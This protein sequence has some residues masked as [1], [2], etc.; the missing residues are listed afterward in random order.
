MNYEKIIL[1]LMSRIQY[2]EE[3]IEKLEYRVS[4][5]DVIGDERSTET[6]VNENTKYTRTDARNRIISRIS[7]EY[8]DYSVERAS[9]ADGSGIRVI[10]LETGD[11]Y[12]IKYYHSKTVLNK[13]EGFEY[14]DHFIRVRELLDTYPKFCIFSLVDSSDRWY[15]FIYEIEELLQYHH[16]RSQAKNDDVMHLYFS[17][18]SDEA[19]I[20]TGR[21]VGRENVSKHLD[22]WSILGW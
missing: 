9:R 11:Q 12:I 3:A 21:D 1:E 5:I 20:T 19:F 6:E 15:Y 8:P 7:E 16:D 13:T 14:G 2:L 10:N 18:Q 17:I 4:Q 22:N